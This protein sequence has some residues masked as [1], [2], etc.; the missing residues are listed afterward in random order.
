MQWIQR[1][2]V[3]L[4]I[5]VGAGEDGQLARG[6]RETT[7]ARPLDASKLRPLRREHVHD[8]DGVARHGVLAVA[9]E[10]APELEA[11]REKVAVRPERAKDKGVQLSLGPR[12]SQL[13]GREDRQRSFQPCGA[14]GGQVHKRGALAL[15]H[16]DGSIAAL[17]TFGAV[18]VRELGLTR[19]RPPVSPQMTWRA[20][21]PFLLPAPCARAAPQPVR[22]RCDGAR[23]AR[24]CPAASTPSSG[25]RCGR[26]GSGGP[27]ARDPWPR[28]PFTSLTVDRLFLDMLMCPFGE[29]AW[30]QAPLRRQPRALGS[31]A[32]G[33]VRVA[34][35]RD[36]DVVVMRGRSPPVMTDDTHSHT[37]TVS[38]E[39]TT[40]RRVR[41]CN[42]YFAGVRPT[43]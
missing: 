17:A 42:L 5:R 41:I 39:T 35:P 28:A 10:V 13:G 34:R 26:R 36:G 15:E 31:I 32:V 23:V 7:E 4:A 37:S 3:Q 6:R 29:V 16:L 20:A 1:P 2:E 38:R 30:A 11:R 33:H 40:R 21:L 22:R 18:W 8:G 25:P 27:E 12:E 9:Q 43:G 24:E 14:L 19:R